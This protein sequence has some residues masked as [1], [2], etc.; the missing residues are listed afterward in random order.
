ML[1]EVITPAA[2][3]LLALAGENDDAGLRVLACVREGIDQLAHGSRPK[4]IAHGG[5]IDP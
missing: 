1:Y 4:R 5:P 3:G 2:E